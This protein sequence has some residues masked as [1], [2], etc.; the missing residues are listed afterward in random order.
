MSRHAAAVT[1]SLAA[2]TVISALN[3]PAVASGEQPPEAQAA[4]STRSSVPS[5]SSI[6]LPR[7]LLMDMPLSVA[8]EAR[9]S[10][11]QLGPD[12]LTLAQLSTLLWA[13]DGVSQ[14]SPGGTLRTAPS[15]GA[16]YPIEL[17]CFVEHVAGLPPGL[18]H[19]LP[20]NHALALIRQGSHQAEAANSAWGQSPLRE[21][22]LTIAATAVFERCCSRYGERG[23][24]YVYQEGGHI[25][26]NVY[27]AAAAMGLRT[28]VIGA[29]SDE[30]LNA[31]LGVDGSAEAALW[32]HPIGR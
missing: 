30:R 24:R 17:Y 16:L 9:R 20:S 23:H 13:A 19:Y 27:L 10:R 2:W 8:L 6:A 21:A 18:Y 26:Q 4:R 25:S 28:V 29:F 11:R 1:A 5:Q 32:L 7:V 15:A 3:S 22:P 31:A 12:S 14:R